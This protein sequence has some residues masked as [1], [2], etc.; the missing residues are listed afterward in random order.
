MDSRTSPAI[1]RSSLSTWRSRKGNTQVLDE[2]D[3]HSWTQFVSPKE[4]FTGCCFLQKYRLGRSQQ[5]EVFHE[6]SQENLEAEVHFDGK[7][8]PLPQNPIKETWQIE[9]ALQ[10]QMDVQRKL[11]E[12]MEVQRHLQLRIEAQGKYLQTVLKKAQETFSGQGS[13]LVSIIESG[14]PSSL[15]SESTMDNESASMTSSGRKKGK[16][17]K[18]GADLSLMGGMDEREKCIIDGNGKKRINGMEEQKS[19]SGTGS[20]KRSSA[21]SNVAG[22]PWRKFLGTLDLNSQCVNDFDS[23]PKAMIDLN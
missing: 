13:P 10:M 15:L 9:Q 16:R 7:F 12:Q 3:G 14:Y 2:G 8:S 18:L 6:S 4:S 19:S 22:E 17:L 21:A 20:V 5:S 1:P 11:H 23:G